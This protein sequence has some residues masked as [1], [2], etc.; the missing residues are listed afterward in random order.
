MDKSWVEKQK[1]EEENKLN[2]YNGLYNNKELLMKRWNSL[3]DSEPKF[4]SGDIII[5]DPCYIMKEN[6][7]IINSDY[8]DVRKYLKYDFQMTN[9]MIRDTL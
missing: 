9:Y 7:D 8:P 4:F 5:T 6:D 3:L 2:R 1:K